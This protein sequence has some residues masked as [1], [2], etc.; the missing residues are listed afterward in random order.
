MALYGKMPSVTYEDYPEARL[1]IALGRQ[2]VGVRHPPGARTSARRRGAAPSWSSSIRG[3]RRWPSR[4]TSTWPCGPAPTCRSRW[5]FIATCSRKATPTRR[6]SPRTRAAPSGCASGRGRGRSSAPPRRPASP[7]DA[8]RRVAELYA[9]TSPGADPLRLGP[10]AQ[11]QRRQR[12][13]WPS[14]RCRRSPE[15]SA[16]AAAA[17]R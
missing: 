8:L 7:A 14:W 15:S 6:S 4:P 5:R 12:V 9:A 16:C 3:R 11:P 17:T 10:G 13:A 2:P 1:I